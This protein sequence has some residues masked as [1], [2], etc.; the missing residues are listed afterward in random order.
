VLPPA[1][2]SVFNPRPA[3]IVNVQA[4]RLK[5][6]RA[7]LCAFEPPDGRAFPLKGPQSMPSNVIPFPVRPAIQRNQEE[8]RFAEFLASLSP[9]DRRR[10]ERAIE[11]LPF[12]QAVAPER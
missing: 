8:R 7:T 9:T 12:Y 6:D 1:K 5:G 4:E 10:V 11:I 3:A 2:Y